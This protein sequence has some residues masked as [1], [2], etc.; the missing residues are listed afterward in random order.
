VKQIND[1]WRLRVVVNKPVV[2]SATE[3]TPHSFEH[4][5]G[6]EIERIVSVM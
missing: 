2:I 1:L 6:I 5:E 3:V 4:Q